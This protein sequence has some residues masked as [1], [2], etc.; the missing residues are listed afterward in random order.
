MI[1]IMFSPT[2]VALPEKVRGQRAGGNVFVSVVV[3]VPL[4][5]A[6]KG[7]EYVTV[8]GGIQAVSVTDTEKS[9]S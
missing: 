9:I 5:L 6:V 7:T 1:D 3:N 8:P 4:G 2:K